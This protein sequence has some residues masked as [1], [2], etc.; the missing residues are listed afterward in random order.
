[1]SYC[2]PFEQGFPTR[3]FCPKCKVAGPALKVR[4]S[5]ST[6]DWQNRCN[7]CGELYSAMP[8]GDG[9]R[10]RAIRR[11]KRTERMQEKAGQISLFP[12]EVIRGR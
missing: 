11:A 6:T 3:I 8:P 2:P 7:A 5:S 1:V 4:A 9:G 10:K 12:K